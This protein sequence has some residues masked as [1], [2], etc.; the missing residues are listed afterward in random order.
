MYILWLPYVV[1]TFK[2]LFIVF[3]SMALR[4]TLP[5]YRF[6][7]LTQLNWKQFIFIWF[8]FLINSTIF[9]T[10]FCSTINFVILV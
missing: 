8:I 10:T 4:A 9:L 5:R 3:W 6:D 7:Q 1:V 2:S